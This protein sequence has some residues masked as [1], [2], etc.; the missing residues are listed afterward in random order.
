MQHANRRQARS[1]AAA[2]ARKGAKR[3]DVLYDLE[4]RLASNDLVEPAADFAV[5]AGWQSHGRIVDPT[6]TI[7]CCHDSVIG[8]IQCCN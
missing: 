3:M 8:T 2:R 1:Q 4:P 6:V 5:E 7:I